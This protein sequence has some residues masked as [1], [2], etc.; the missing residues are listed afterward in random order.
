M[1]SESVLGNVIIAVPWLRRPRRATG[2]GIIA[3]RDQTLAAALR[4]KDERFAPVFGAGVLISEADA[5]GRFVYLS[6]NA[7]DFL[8]RPRE[9]LLGKPTLEHVHPEDREFIDA[10]RNE[11]VL[12][13]PTD[14]VRATYRVVLPDDSIRWL[15]T[16]GRIEVEGGGAPTVLCVSLDVTERMCVEEALRESEERFARAFRSSPSMLVI[17]DIEGRVLDVNEAFVAAVGYSREEVKGRVG[18]SSGLWKSAAERAAVMERLRRRGS[19]R[20]IEWEYRRRSGRPGWVLL[21]ANVVALGGTQVVVWQGIDLTERKRAEAAL[22]ESQERFQKVFEAG[23]LAV[24]IADLD[25]TV[26]DVNESF[27]RLSGWAREQVVG[28]NGSELGWD[29]PETRAAALAQI[30]ETGSAREIEAS[31]TGPRGERARMLL[32]AVGVELAGRQCVLWQG[33]DVTERERT[34]AEL[35]RHRQHLEELVEARTRALAASRD[36][37]QARID[38]LRASEERYRA[39]AENA[40]DLI[41]EWDAQGRMVYANAAWL[42]TLGW[43]VDALLG[44][45]IEYLVHPGDAAR[46]LELFRGLLDTGR[47]Y[48]HT[49]RMRHREG[50]WRWVEGNATRFRT[51]EG[52]A[53]VMAIGRDVTEHRRM[54]EELERSER[55]A[56]IGT[57][58]AG[59]AHEINN[60]VASILLAAQYAQR[61]RQHPDAGSITDRA[62][63]DVVENARRCGRIVRSVLHFSQQRPSDLEPQDL[64]DVVRGALDLV[65]REAELRAV[66]LVLELPRE[67]LLVRMNATQIEQV[68]VNLVQNAI[69]S[70]EECTRVCVAAESLGH[71]ARLRVQ[72]DGPGI[73]DRDRRRVFDPFF[74]TRHTTGGSGLGLSVSHGIV[75]QHG[76]SVELASEPGKGTRVNVDLPL[77][78]GVDLAPAQDDREAET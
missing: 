68:V 16:S 67:P 33:I 59:I 71:A 48:H 41:G 15:E 31:F 46:G 30:R 75:V 63:A 22:R 70:G 56:S 21:S 12:D 37:L 50:S 19:L 28:R 74:T 36:E 35:A 7:I 42:H 18:L 47:G 52:E 10:R 3:S 73:A 1:G 54:Q 17:T 49:L 11:V 39:L 77:A 8:G 58:A 69:A 45:H 55:L 76:G 20:H 13:S 64:R 66:S 6:P 26:I 4:A 5:E 44:T 43:S 23:P 57:L 25:G 72:D 40:H 14:V 34:R 27:L 24:V 32:S 53:R 65:R 2:E 29:D 38:A 62:L 51:A 9:E 60:P 78:G 61:R